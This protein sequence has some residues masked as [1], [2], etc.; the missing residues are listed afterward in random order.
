M[1]PP[2]TS[3]IVTHQGSMI[4][5]LSL[6]VCR[7][8]RESVQALICTNVSLIAECFI[9]SLESCLIDRSADRAVRQTEVTDRCVQVVS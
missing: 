9:A 1:P 2:H 5:Q 7:V 4:D 6:A 3:L 8:F